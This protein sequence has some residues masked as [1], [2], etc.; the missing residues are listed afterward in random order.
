MFHSV[1]NTI[2]EFCSLYFCVESIWIHI[3]SD[4]PV[5][6]LGIFCSGVIEV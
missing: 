3:F 4:V 1:L 5:H 2:V 6:S